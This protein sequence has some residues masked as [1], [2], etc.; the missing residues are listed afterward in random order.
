MQMGVPLDD[1]TLSRMTE[2]ERAFWEDFLKE[3]FQVIDEKKAKDETMPFTP[4]SS[5]REKYDIAITEHDGQK[6]CQ[7]RQLQGVFAF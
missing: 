1:D 7:I 3:A 4:P 2:E 6:Y 5:L